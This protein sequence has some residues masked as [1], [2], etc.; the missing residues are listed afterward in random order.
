MCC[1]P[2]FGDPPPPRG[3]IQQVHP[4]P[5][6]SFGQPNIQLM[7]RNPMMQTNMMPQT[8]MMPQTNMMQLSNMLTPQEHQMFM[9]MQ[10]QQQQMYMMGKQ[11]QM[12]MLMQQAQ[13]MPYMQGGQSTTGHVTTI[14]KNIDDE[15]E[16]GMSNGAVIA[17]VGAG[18]LAGGIGG[19]V[20]SGGIDGNDIANVGMQAGDAIGD[21]GGTVVDGVGN[22]VDKV[23]FSV[24]GD[25]AG[26]VVEG[27]GDVIGGVLDGLG[28]LF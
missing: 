6:N 26:D 1:C 28:S 15:K 27:A 8:G 14:Y 13:S 10:P 11:Q 2:C 20:L 25:V 23:D 17:A 19:A 12:M 5:P 18:A 21:F 3:R 24:V 7:N 4:Y 9:T 22:L 16:G